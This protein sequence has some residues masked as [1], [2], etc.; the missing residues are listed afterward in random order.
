MRILLI[1]DNEALADATQE[2]F[3]QIGHPLDWTVSVEM[4]ERTL[5]WDDFDM[6]ILDI[7]LPG[8][9]GYQLLQSLR[10]KGRTIPVLILTARAEID[11]RVSALDLGADDYLV[12]PVDFRELAARCRALLRRERG[13]A[14][15]TMVCGNLIFNL[16][17]HQITVNNQAVELRLRERQLLELFLKNLDRV[18]TKEDIANKLYTFDEAN[19]PN[20]IEQTLTRLRKK[21]SES[22]LHIKTIRGLGYL[23]HIDD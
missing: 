22:S 17:T 7:N 3:R 5:S 2:Y 14:S 19:T 11:D 20:A 1:E 18:L 10:Q 16:A 12:K 21:L 23:G 6:L 4:A 15:N 8:R 9:S 13:A